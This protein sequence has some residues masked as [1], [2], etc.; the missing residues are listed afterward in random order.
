MAKRPPNKAVAGK[1]QGLRVAR[2]SLDNSR[3]RERRQDMVPGVATPYAE[4]LRCARAV[5]L[6][7]NADFESLAGGF[8]R[9]V[10]RDPSKRHR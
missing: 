3:A 2:L 6:R 5:D 9:V 10:V 8:V 4:K 7:D 1:G